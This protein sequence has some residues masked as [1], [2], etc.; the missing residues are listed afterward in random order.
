M[1]HYKQNNFKIN[2]LYNE[3]ELLRLEWKWSWWHLL[4]VVVASVTV[5][6]NVT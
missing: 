4:L 5:C 6:K 3:F 1:I 2:S